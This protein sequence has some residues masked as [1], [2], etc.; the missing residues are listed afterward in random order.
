MPVH[1]RNP[2]AG[3]LCLPQAHFHRYARFMTNNAHDTRLNPDRCL[4]QT[5]QTGFTVIELMVTI[6]IA[7]IMM[8]IA[9]PSFQSFLLNSRLTGHTNDLV[10]ALAYAKSEA[11]K[12]GANV[13]V[14]PS[15]DEATCSGDWEDGWIVATAAGEVLQVHTAYTGTICGSATAINFRNSGF[16][17]AGITFDLYDSRGIADGRRIVVSAQ[18]RATTTTG[19]TTCS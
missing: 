15:D 9:V 10:L 8:A 3:H 19:A 6:S 4:M 5:R 1:S 7:A 18:G 14:C 16:P 17:V 12:R 11:V 13:T 2:A